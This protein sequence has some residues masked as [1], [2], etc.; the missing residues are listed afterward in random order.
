MNSDQLIPT[1][2]F[3]TLGLVLAV[4]IFQ[5]VWTMRKKRERENTPLTQTSEDQRRSGDSVVNKR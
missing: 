4:G 5:Y 1:L 2:L 3:T